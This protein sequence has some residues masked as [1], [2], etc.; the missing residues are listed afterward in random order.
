MRKLKKDG[1]LRRDKIILEASSG[2]TGI[3]LA[4]VGRLKRYKVKIVMPEDASEERKRIIESYGAEL[5][6]T[7][8]EDGVDGAQ[9]RANEMALDEKYFM[10]NQYVNEANVIAHYG[11][12]GKE[13]LGQVPDVTHFVA[14]MGTGGTLMGV[15]KRLKEFNSGIKVIGAEPHKDSKIPGLKNMEVSYVPEI[16]DR[17]QIDETLI[18]A[19]EDA[20]EMSDLLFRKEGLFVGPSSG[21]AMSAAM[22]MSEKIAKG[23]IVVLFPD[24]GERYLAKKV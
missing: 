6:L 12:T 18:V 9:D 5:V 21:A 8:A 20:I 4:L 17:G 19:G 15:G 13:I 11:G 24:G 2:N 10:P 1:V 23:N 22:K 3:G 14:G 16:F 7:P